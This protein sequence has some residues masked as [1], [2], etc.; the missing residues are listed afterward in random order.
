MDAPKEFTG[1][2]PETIPVP[3]GI[4]GKQQSRMVQ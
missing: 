1:F 4:K 3:E 2:T